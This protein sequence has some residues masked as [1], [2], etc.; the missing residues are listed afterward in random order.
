MEKTVYNCEICSFK[1]TTKP[2]LARHIYYRHCMKR[3]LYCPIC[4]VTGK[5]V[6]NLI[7]HG[8]SIH[9]QVC[10]SS[11]FYKLYDVINFIIIIY[12]TFKFY[13]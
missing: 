7:N 3:P 10:F 12:K 8:A 4:G 2:N 1:L 6:N 5:S 13:F 11:D 9:S